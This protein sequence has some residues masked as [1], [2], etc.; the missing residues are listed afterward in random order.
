MKSAR[1]AIVAVLALALF[2]LPVAAE[3]NA[4]APLAK[5]GHGT[6]QT[7]LFKVPDL[8]A[9]LS[10]ELVKGLAK[11]EGIVSAKP[12][13]DKASFAVTF[14]PAKTDAKQLQVSL[15]EI[16]SQMSLTKVGPADPKHAKSDCGKCPH[17]AKCS[18]KK[19]G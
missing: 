4:T 1:N 10:K 7:A 5:A 15:R 18:K 6:P 12:D 19:D 3:D 9:D 14:D 8:T 11:L 16:A 2:V 17:E 13:L